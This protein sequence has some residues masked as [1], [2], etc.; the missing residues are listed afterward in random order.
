MADE[1]TPTDEQVRVGFVAALQWACEAEGGDVDETEALA[2]YDR[3]LAAHDAQVR[4]K[5]KV[6]ALREAAD[7]DFNQEPLYSGP[8]PFDVLN[9]RADRIERE[10]GEGE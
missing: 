8:H 4:R 1:Y 2:S 6:E 3:W 5:A 9:A 7:E 10:G